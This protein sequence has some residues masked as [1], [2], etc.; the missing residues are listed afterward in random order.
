ML[1]GPNMQ[2]VKLRP[3]VEP[4]HNTID[5]TIIIADHVNP[6]ASM[7]DDDALCQLCNKQRI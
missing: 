7:I 6:I 1:V 3:E 5:G 2:A 4:P